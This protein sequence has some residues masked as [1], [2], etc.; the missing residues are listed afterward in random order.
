MTPRVL[1]V[2]DEEDF[3]QALAGRLRRRGLTVWTAGG[4]EE[5]LGVVSEHHPTVVVLDVVMPGIDGISTLRQIKQDTGDV[6]VILLTGHD[7][8]D[9]ALDGMKLGAFDF[10]LKP[11]DIDELLRRIEGAHDRASRRRAEDPGRG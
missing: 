1:L 6:E 10:L 3:V 5:A 11:T 9:V 7:A 4:G 8:V 2:D